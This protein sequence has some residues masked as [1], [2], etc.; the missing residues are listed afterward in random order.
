[1]VVVYC[2]DG[3]AVA[4][5]A[6]GAAGV[7]FFFWFFFGCAGTQI[8]VLV[9]TRGLNPALGGEV[10]GSRGFARTDDRHN[11]R[12]RARNLRTSRLITI[13]GESRA[14]TAWTTIKT[15]TVGVGKVRG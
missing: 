10:R 11:H 13:A 9:R 2:C 4:A 14:R 12:Q 8:Y 5:G 1:M 3:T 7:V 6:A 15:Y